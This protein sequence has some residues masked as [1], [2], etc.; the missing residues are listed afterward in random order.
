MNIKKMRKLV[1]AA[2]FSAIICVATFVV[3]IPS[4]ATGGY[5]NLGDCFV[6]LAGLYLGIGYGAFAAG[7]GSAL[8]DILSGYVHYAPATFIIK[9]I[10]AITFCFV[11]KAVSKRNHKLAKLT[12][13]LAAESIM[14]FGYFAYEAVILKYGIAAFGSIISNTFQGIIGIVAAIAISVA[15]GKSKTLTN[16]FKG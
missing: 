11:F 5:F 10:M 2:L 12:G 13:G 8:A 6:L 16:Y 15:I 14:I 7:L 1:T 4:P 3:K 9:Y